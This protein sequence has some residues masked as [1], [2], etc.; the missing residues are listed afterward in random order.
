VTS[1]AVAPDGRSAWFG[2]HDRAGVPYLAYVEDN[3][4]PGRDDVFKLWIRGVLQTP[5]DGAL[6]GGNVQIHE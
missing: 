5:A 2:G 6:A 3:G 4:E 1:L